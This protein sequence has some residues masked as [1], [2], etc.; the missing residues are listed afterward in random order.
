MVA[1]LGERAGR[2]ERPTGDRCQPAEGTPEARDVHRRR[3]SGD[4]FDW[5]PGPVAGPHA[6][7]RGPEADEREP[8]PADCRN[9]LQLVDGRTG[10]RRG[11][12]TSVVTRAGG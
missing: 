12:T 2:Q 11:T 1:I 8:V 9:V 6:H 7:G 3:G 4:C 5:R 10:A